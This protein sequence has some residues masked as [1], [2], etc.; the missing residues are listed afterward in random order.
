MKPSGTHFRIVHG[1]RGIEI[2]RFKAGSYTLEALVPYTG[3]KQ[4]DDKTAL[5]KAR[6]LMRGTDALH[7]KEDQNSET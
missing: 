7:T 1:E 2:E 5:E 4:L 6:E 3:N